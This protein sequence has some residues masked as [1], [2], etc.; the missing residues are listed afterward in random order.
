VRGERAGDDR[1]ASA[2]RHFVCS[3]ISILNPVLSHE[4]AHTLDSILPELYYRSLI[5]S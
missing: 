1:E 4:I 5:L 2:R 3:A